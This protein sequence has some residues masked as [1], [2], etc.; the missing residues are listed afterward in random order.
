MADT[1]GPS[2]G[3][4]SSAL[5][6]SD[7]HGPRLPHPIPLEDLARYADGL[8][9]EEVKSK[10]EQ[11]ESNEVDTSTSR[12]VSAIL[13]SNLFTVF[14]AILFTCMIAVLAVGDWRDAVFGFVLILNLAI[15][16]LSEL[17]NKRT[18]DSL[19]VLQAP[20]SVV[21]R[22]GEWTEILNGDLVTDD[23]IE[24]KLGDQIPADG[25]ILDSTGLEIDES[26]L[27]GESHPVHKTPGDQALSGTAVIAGSG[28]M[29]VEVIGS[30]A[31]AQ[32][33]TAEARKYSQAR[34]EIQESIT[35]VLTWITMILP[36]LVILLVWSQF[37]SGA[38]DWRT[39]IIYT[40]AGVV[41][42]I[43][44]GLVLLTSMNFG[45]A[46][47]SLAR[48]GVLIQELPAVEI[49]AR[50]DVFC[51]DKTG[52]LTT[53]EIR[54]REIVTGPGA[55]GRTITVR[56]EALSEERVARTILAAMVA[57]DTNATAEAVGEL[58]VDPPEG[59]T[60]VADMI[61]FN[62]AR[63]WSAVTFHD[64]S[65]VD[66]DHATWVFGAPE[67]LLGASP[68]V[69]EWARRTVVEASKLG[70]RT[71]C[72]AYTSSPLNE[73]E[74][75]LPPTLTPVFVVVLEE[76]IRPDA[77]QTLEYFERQGVTIKVISGDSPPT[78][79]A[80]ATEVGL[81]GKDEA[82]LVIM[83]ARNL[84][85]IG[86]PEFERRALATDVFGRVTP[87]QKRALVHTLQKS[88][89]TV[90]MT[91]DG[92]NDALALKDADLGIAMGN[93]AP[94]TK[95][96][97]RVVL[98][99]GKFS[100]LP[101]MVGE[102][103]R[104]IANMERVSS[105]FLAKTTYAIL[106]AIVVAIVAWEYPFLPRQLTYIGTFTIGV[107]AFFLSLAANHTKYTPG[108]LKRTLLIAVPSGTFLAGAALT[109]YGLIGVATTP[110]QTA[111]TISLIIGAM[112]L[113]IILAQPWNWWR[114]TLV[115]LM[116]AGAVLGIVI[117]IIRT[118]F[119]LSIPAGSQWTTIL[120][121]GFTAAILI[122]VSYRVT[123]RWREA[124]A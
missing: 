94:A 8:T 17:R 50:V 66:A 35:K 63:K 47:A 91:G 72:L 36:L 32:T 56:G 62:S 115:L 79:G 124:A 90:A 3:G 58:L 2:Q 48:K 109:S 81:R 57:D 39:A 108:F 70:R 30:Q 82:G 69:P 121:A 38:G 59:F 29:L 80:I 27:T 24:L 45:L 95:A 16:V 22:D 18:L 98:V 104:I 31:W 77:K 54:G 96:V 83:D 49:L 101:G 89:H 100:D 85:E 102:G 61:P 93:A 10:R 65:I 34:S 7:K 78:V 11:G 14:N 103:R 118:F 37:R 110:G 67:I 123:K 26:A 97:S 68:T 52:T 41:G 9:S 92:V 15:G 5:S 55:S 23:V 64:S 107:P 46:A 114:I 75:A 33:I 1:E 105:L 84:P 71:V 42:M 20:T 113:L 28:R 13:R 44:Q 43:P 73:D 87:E 21:L 119:A 40:V 86:S 106:I 76:D 122:A 53:G 116:V 4:S 60:D 88:G 51:I 19:A 12:S 112:A 99:N 25:Q 120:I 74:K 111:A 117:P 6:T